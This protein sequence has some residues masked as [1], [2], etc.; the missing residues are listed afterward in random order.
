MKPNAKWNGGS[1][2]SKCKDNIQPLRLEM[3]PISNAGLNFF[4]YLL[5]LQAEKNN[6][7]A[8]R[9]RSCFSAHSNLRANIDS[10]FEKIWAMSF[11]K[12]TREVG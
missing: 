1:K 4:Y 7:L 8:E 10:L 2:P 5:Y 6:T 12:E 11:S 3:P 9:E